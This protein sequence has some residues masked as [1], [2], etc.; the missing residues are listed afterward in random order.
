M[1]EGW[2][3]PI[4]AIK[5]CESFFISRKQMKN[6]FLTVQNIFCLYGMKIIGQIINA[7][8]NAEKQETQIK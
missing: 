7:D 1:V 5:R 6:L 2:R 3:R 8:M 4:G